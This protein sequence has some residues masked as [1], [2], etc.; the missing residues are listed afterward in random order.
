MRNSTASTGMNRTG[1]ATSPQAAADLLAAT[2][3]AVPSRRGDATGMAELRVEYARAGE[4]PG[5]MPPPATMK[6]MAKA[7]LKLLQGKSAPVLLDK[8]GERLAFERSGTRLYE[9]LLSKYDAYGSWPDGPSRDDLAHIHDEERQHFL[10]LKEAIEALGGDPTAVTPSANVHAVASEGLPAV[11]ADP[12]TNLQQCME[13]ILIAELVDN[14]C[15]ENLVDLATAVGVQSL[16]DSAKVALEQERE[17]LEKIRRWVGA[18]LSRQAAGRLAEPFATR[19]QTRV[20][21]MRTRAD[22]WGADGATGTKTGT[23]TATKTRR[24]RRS[25]PAKPRRS[26]RRA[27]ASAT[28]RKG[29]QAPQAGSKRRS[30][31]R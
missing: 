31:R 19:D 4:P 15:W 11:L 25:R 3:T 13:V 27:S 17:H 28:Q 2:E 5:S 24:S 1:I 16:A 29:R 22:G 12:R 8:L 23:K 7:A 20:A 10:M 9:A 26:S 18:G 21:A 6:G 14:D 30:R